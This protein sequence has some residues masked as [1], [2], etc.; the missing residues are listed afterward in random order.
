MSVLR[1][2]R[3]LR[4][5]RALSTSA[6]RLSPSSSPAAG[7]TSKISPNAQGLLM[8]A[9]ATAALVGSVVAMEEVRA[10]RVHKAEA[11][12]EA[13]EEGG[14]VAGRVY[15]AEK[16]AEKGETKAD[17]E[18]E[19]WEMLIVAPAVKDAV[20]AVDSGIKELIAAAE[21]ALAKYK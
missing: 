2:A 6:I 18:Y 19:A 8:T 10:S 16:E 21:A 12:I 20:D 7:I 11:E 5:V 17:G 13:G 1:A 15:E 9:V 14:V 3:P 4:H